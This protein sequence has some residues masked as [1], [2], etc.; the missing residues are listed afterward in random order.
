TIPSLIDILLRSPVLITFIVFRI[1]D[2][3][4]DSHCPSSFY[5]GYFYPLLSLYGTI[6]ILALLMFYTSLRGSPVAHTQPRRYMPLLIYIRMILVLIDIGINILGLVIVVRVFKMCDM[7]LRATLL[8]SIALSWSMAIA[9][10]IILAFLIDLTSFVSAEKK[11]EMRIKLIF[12][13]GRGYGK[14]LK[15]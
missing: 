9:L 11:W 4:P 12:C 7:I 1:K 5:N 2:E 15:K 3:S 10:F 8:T 14:I 6:T 13:C